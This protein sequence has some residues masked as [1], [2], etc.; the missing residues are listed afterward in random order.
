MKDDFS[1]VRGGERDGVFARG[2]YGRHVYSRHVCG[3]DVY[4]FFS[5]NC[6]GH[7][8]ANSRYDYMIPS[9]C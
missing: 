6:D 2:V 4:G 5:S 3:C 1:V 9:H 8:H 7:G